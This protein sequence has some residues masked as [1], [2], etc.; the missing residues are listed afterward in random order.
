MTESV[1][2]PML[3]KLSAEKYKTEIIHE[4]LEFCEEHSV[5]LAT[6]HTGTSNG[7]YHPAT[8]RATDLLMA[9]FIG[10]DMNIVEQE[11]SECLS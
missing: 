3:D 2:T 10:V 7:F 6:F 8:Q 1:T 11:G 5:Y 4:F 9:K